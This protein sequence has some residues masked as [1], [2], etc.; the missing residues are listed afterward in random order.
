MLYNILLVLLIIDSIVLILAVLL[1]AGQGGGM[2]A[3][4]FAGAFIG[5]MAGA[6][7]SFVQRKQPGQPA[8]S[9]AQRKKRHGKQSSH[10]YLHES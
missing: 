1:Q 6:A 2:A 10:P 4:G 3:V 7:I 5:V 8:P 9:K